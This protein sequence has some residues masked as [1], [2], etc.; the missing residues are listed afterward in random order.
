MSLQEH[1]CPKCGHLLC[2]ADAVGRVDVPCTKCKKIRTLEL[3][4]AAPRLTVVHAR[5]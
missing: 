3:A 2:K 4:A 1:R 5:P